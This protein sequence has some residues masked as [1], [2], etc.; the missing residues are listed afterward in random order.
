MP[1]PLPSLP[2]G[3]SYSLT[4]LY[5]THV[6]YAF[7][8]CKRLKVTLEVCAQIQ[9]FQLSATFSCS[10]QISPSIEKKCFQN[11]EAYIFILIQ[12]N[13]V[14]PYLTRWTFSP[15]SLRATSRMEMGGAP[16]AFTRAD[17]ENVHFLSTFL[18]RILSHVHVQGARKCRLL[19][20]FSH[21]NSLHP[22]PQP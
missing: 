4:H 21:L 10:D 3:S 2:S 19:L 12:K 9:D 11:N 22:P 17:L 5:S 13:V 6:L 8:Q 14:F 15:G 18:V 20:G 7:I 16:T 1:K